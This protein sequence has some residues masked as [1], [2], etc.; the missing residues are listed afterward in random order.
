[1]MHL[2]HGN[3]IPNALPSARAVVNRRPF[4]D[5][6]T[7]PSWR[8]SC[9]TFCSSGWPRSAWEIRPAQNGQSLR[10]QRDRDEWLYFFHP[11][12]DLYRGDHQLRSEQRAFRRVGFNHQHRCGT[13]L[14]IHTGICELNQKCFHTVICPFTLCR[15]L[16]L[17]VISR[18]S[19]LR[20]SKAQQAG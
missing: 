17:P 18:L 1:M 3:A 20:G 12:Q 7:F 6:E 14:R 4:S 10:T 11:G 9:D 15:K 19:R 16:T 13:A 2:H 8:R 5:A